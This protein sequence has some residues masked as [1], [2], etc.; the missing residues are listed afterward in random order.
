MQTFYQKNVLDRFG[1]NRRK[2]AVSDSVLYSA[3]NSD[4]GER[5]PE[6][7]AGGFEN[8]RGRVKVDNVIFNTIVRVGVADFGNVFYDINLE[9]DAILPHIQDASEIKSVSTPNNSL[10]QK[11]DTVNSYS[12]QNGERRFKQTG[13]VD[14]RCR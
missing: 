8:Y 13:G 1:I 12:M 14:K 7:L 3:H 2:S 9:V 4:A 11:N 5:G 10:T 6:G